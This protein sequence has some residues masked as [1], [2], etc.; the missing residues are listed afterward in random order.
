MVTVRS[1]EASKTPWVIQHILSWIVVTS[2]IPISAIDSSF[3]VHF[4]A[5]FGTIRLYSLMLFNGKREHFKIDTFGIC[6]SS[7]RATSTAFLTG[8]LQ[9]WDIGPFEATVWAH[10][11]EKVA[12]I[13]IFV[14][15]NV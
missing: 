5:S 7:F 8:S 3:V 10:V 11:Q 1:F 6:I 12:V 4:N 13:G 15:P 2:S 9:L 14:H